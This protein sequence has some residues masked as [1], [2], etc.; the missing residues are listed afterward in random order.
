MRKVTQ[1]IKEAF[2]QGKP[3]KVG[4]TE[5]DGSECRSSSIEI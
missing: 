1:Q 4:N 5:T 2:K 3:L